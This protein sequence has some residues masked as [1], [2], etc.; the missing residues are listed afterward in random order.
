MSCRLL[1]HAVSF[2]QAHT[3]R[4]ACRVYEAE[5]K[6]MILCYSTDCFTSAGLKDVAALLPTVLLV[7]AL[8]VTEL[9]CKKKIY[10]QM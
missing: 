1:L 9:E 2:T 6:G 10:I 7:S 3:T 8:Y 5:G 4:K